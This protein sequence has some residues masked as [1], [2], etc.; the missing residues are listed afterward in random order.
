[1][2]RHQH[3]DLNC[4][5]CDSNNWYTKGLTENKQRRRFKCRECDHHWMVFVD[6]LSSGN[7]ELFDDGKPSVE[8]KESEDR[9]FR[10]PVEEVET[11]V[12]SHDVF[13]ITSLQND[14]P[15]NYDFFASLKS[16]CGDRSARLMIIP[17]KYKN[18]SLVNMSSD[19]TWDSTLTDYMIRN[20]IHLSDNIKIL[21]N[22]PISAT[23][24]NP[25]S[26]LEPMT[27]GKTTI[28]GHS[29][30]ASTTAPVNS[31]DKPIILSTTGSLSKDGY[32]SESKAGFKANF[33]HTCSALVVEID[34][35]TGL[36]HIRQLVADSSGAFFDIHG[37]YSGSKIVRNIAS[38]ALVLGDEHALFSSPEVYEATFGSGG[39]VDTVK[40]RNL[41]RHDVLDCHTISHH[42]SKKPMKKFLKMVQGYDSIEDELF[43]TAKY[44]IDTTRRGQKSIVVNSNH[45]DHLARWLEEGDPKID[46]TNAVIYHQLMYLML[47]HIRQNE[48]EANAFELWFKTH[49]P[50]TD[51]IIFDSPKEPIY[52]EGIN[53]SMHGDL[54]P[55]GSRGSR[56]NLS[57]MPDKSVIGHSHSPGI[58]KGCWQVGTSSVLN[59]DYAKGPTTW[60]NTHC[61]IYPNGKRQL[62]NIIGGEWRKP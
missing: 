26:G 47:N 61:I 29:Q 21:A 22:C 24:M 13:V 9:D 55:N 27:R 44:L 60:M 8:E 62:I 49:Y 56:K 17:V 25:L 57:R 19:C 20:E 36:H 7:Y 48:E 28:F 35:Y 3:Y 37:Y 42:H 23:A 30:L 41:V 14:T 33:N 31:Y 53:V 18:P 2:G 52:I 1:M 32:Y 10:L 51:D 38:S 34:R 45:H 54:G 58:E 4:P 15:T 5:E 11:I 50:D 59:L 39:I 12:N 6:E 40:P 46:P 16:Y 43:L